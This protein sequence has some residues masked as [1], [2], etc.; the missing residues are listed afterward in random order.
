MGSDDEDGDPKATDEDVYHESEEYKMRQWGILKE[1]A[2]WELLMD[3]R[4]KKVKQPRG[5]AKKA[6]KKVQEVEI[7]DF[8]EGEEGHRF[9]THLDQVM[10]EYHLVKVKVKI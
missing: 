8:A 9:T 4:A 6:K 5:K 2:E 1:R 10:M 7:L 3:S